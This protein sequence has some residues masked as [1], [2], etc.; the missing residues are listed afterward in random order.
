MRAS[1]PGEEPIHFQVMAGR[2]R[3]GGPVIEPH[4]YDQ[5]ESKADADDP[6]PDVRECLTPGGPGAG[7]VV[8][9][10]AWNV[11]PSEV[12]AR[13]RHLAGRARAGGRA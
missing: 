13:W 2:V 6:R 7:T 11:R 8:R 1:D 10:E 5:R 3:A 4:I 9:V 12:R